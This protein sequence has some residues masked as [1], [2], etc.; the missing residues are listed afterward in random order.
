MSGSSV[1]GARRK[2]VSRA[3]RTN[4]KSVKHS[5]KDQQIHLTQRQ[6]QQKLYRTKNEWS[7]DR[8]KRPIY[9]ILIFVDQW[10]ISL[11]TDAH[12]HMS[13]FMCSC[14]LSGVNKFP[15]FT[16]AAHRDWTT[17]SW[18]SPPVELTN[19]QFPTDLPFYST[20]ERESC[21]LWPA[22]PYGIC[23]QHLLHSSSLSVML[24]E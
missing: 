14:D 6:Q 2:M 23:G 12:D 15:E 1:V 7:A 4:S 9:R 20:S 17:N 22:W 3:C 11:Y 10:Q 18:K 13:T 19:E 21:S 16:R 8:V 24:G 5:H